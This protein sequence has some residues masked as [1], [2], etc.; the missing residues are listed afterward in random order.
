MAATAPPRACRCLP[1]LVTFARKQT[2]RY[3]R[4]AVTT[5]IFTVPVA[6]LE[7]GTKTIHWPLPQEWLNRALADCGAEARDDGEVSLELSLNGREVLVRGRASVGLT[8][9]CVSTLEPVDVDL[10]PELFLLLVPASPAAGSKHRRTGKAARPGRKQGRLLQDAAQETKGWARDPE[11]SHED[12]ARDTYDGERVVLDDF[13]RE[14]ILLELPMA[15]RRSDLHSAQD[16][17][18]PSAP[19]GTETAR[20]PPVDPRLAPLAQIADRLR[21][22]K[23]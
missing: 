8:M 9:P 21:R 18:N 17:A 5:P 7:A 6:D 22:N 11:L 14:F 23:E 19:S 1:A 13:L 2:R 4:C 12:A 15:P 20:E 10:T 16:A 3:R